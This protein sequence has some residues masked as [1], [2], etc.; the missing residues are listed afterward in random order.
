MA[1]PFPQRNLKKKSSHRFRVIVLLVAVA[2]LAYVVLNQIQLNQDTR[3][4]TIT[5]NQLAK[6]VQSTVQDPTCAPESPEPPPS[7]SGCLRE[8]RIRGPEIRGFYDLAEPERESKKLV[9]VNYPFKTYAPAEGA[10]VG[11]IEKL[12]EN[13]RYDILVRAEGSENEHA[14][15]TTLGVMWLPYLLL[16]V[17]I[18]LLFAILRRLKT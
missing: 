3:E 5:Y 18:S 7:D 2:V 15:W 13:G 10:I 4:R 17:I 14:F 16:L 11:L 12:Q 6:I 9:S 1:A 8:L